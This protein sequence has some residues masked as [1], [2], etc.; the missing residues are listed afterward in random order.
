MGKH[1]VDPEKNPLAFLDRLLPGDEERNTNL[2]FGDV[3][4]W[5]HIEYVDTR[6][7]YS[8]KSLEYRTIKLMFC[9]CIFYLVFLGFLT[10]FIVELRSKSVY[11][12]QSQQFEYWADCKQRQPSSRESAVITDGCTFYDVKDVSNI[13]PWIREAFM[14]KAFTERSLFPTIVEVPSIL[15]LHQDTTAWQPRYIGDTQ[16]TVLV[17]AIRLRQ[18]RTQKIKAEECP[19]LEQLK[20]AVSGDSGVAASG[21]S[22]VVDACYPPFT[23]SK[24]SKVVWNPKETPAHLHHHYKFFK[25]N[26]TMQTTM[27]G[28][29]G[30][31]PGDGFFFDIPYNLTGAQGRLKELEHWSWINHRTRAIILEWTTL[32]I[33]LNIMVHH[34]M[35]FEVPATGGVSTRYE[36]FGFRVVELAMWLLATDETHIFMLWI[37]ASACHLLLFIYTIWL[38][39]K[40]R[41]RFFTFFWGWCD[42]L[43]LE[44]FFDYMM[45]KLTVYTKRASHPYM[46][47]ETLADPE[48]FYPVGHLVSDMQLGTDFLAILGLVAWFRVLK[49]FTLIST[50]HPF[51]KVIERTVYQ[52]ILFAGLLFIVVFGF[53]VAFH[54][55]Y[56]GTTDL[57]STLLGSF[58]A[59]IVAPA[60][61]VDFSPVLQSGDFLGALLLFMYVILI[62]FLLISTF[63]AIVVDTYSVTFFQIK[64]VMGLDPHTPSGVFWWTYFNALRNTKLVGKETEDEKGKLDEQQILLSSLPEAI[65]RRFQETK[66]KMLALKADAEAEIQQKNLEKLRAAGK[67]DDDVFPD[68]PQ[69][70]LLAIQDNHNGKGPKNLPVDE[71]EFIAPPAGP[72][73]SRFT[74]LLSETDME[75]KVDR[76][77]LQRMLNEDEIFREICDTS[78]AIDIVRRFQ[79]ENCDADPYEA[80]EKLQ[81]EVAKKIAEMESMP[82][83][84]LSFDELETLK[85]VSAE[86]HHALTESQKE[87]RSELLSVMQM[88][89][90]LSK[91][92]VEL[93]RK[94]EAVQSNHNQLT[95]ML[96]RRD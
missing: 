40:N 76:V 78:A 46:G 47:P 9:E 86:L 71:V 2:Y 68:E 69:T 21:N 64:E 58:I 94:M 53:A 85:A 49:Y 8:T 54:I 92:L 37:V 88:A 48:M 26:A 6:E 96:P 60:G 59:C 45:V 79:V 89:S 67:I 81:H 38:I 77:Q 22:G 7:I 19:F 90:L 72:G 32:N 65:S 39:W 27:Q 84:R 73:P 30:T 13:G 31:Y 16:T 56:G 15:R 62:V 12:M 34:R 51:V 28:Y 10:G 1:G 63:M 29:H 33:N 44:L 95:T 91:S 42:L 11:E 52:L 66:H 61:G 3:R 74:S 14:P 80:V 70:G 83:H 55:S 75:T 93:T 36:V 24:Q 23:E 82:G 35:L 41:L 5:K 57:F 43:I 25:A 4:F 17:G 18:L 50:F 87:W 20:T